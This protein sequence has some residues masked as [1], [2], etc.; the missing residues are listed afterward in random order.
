M[1]MLLLTN[2]TVFDGTSPE[3]LEGQSVVIED[4]VIRELGSNVTLRGDARRVDVGGR[5]VM[6]G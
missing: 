1:T 2:C 3:L 6:P 5:F 4:G